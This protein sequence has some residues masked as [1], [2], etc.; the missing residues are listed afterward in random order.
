MKSTRI[1]FGIAVLAFAGSALA[2]TDGNSQTIEV[3]S[4]PRVELMTIIFRL[5]GNPEFNQSIT[6]PY[7]RDVD[8][9]FAPF[10]DHEA[11]R[12]ARRLRN[13]SSVSYD[14]VISMAMHVDN[15]FDLRERVPF[16]PQ[17]ERLD[18][19]W[20]ADEA[21]EF[22][23]LARQFVQDTGFKEF[24][25]KHEKI[26]E[27]TASRLKKQLH[28]RDYLD[29]LADFFGERPGAKFIAIPGMLTGGGCFASGIKL[30]NHEEEICMV[31]GVWSTD[32]RGRPRFGD[33]IIP[34][35]VHE[36][37]HSYTNPI[38]NRHADDLAAVGQK[39]FSAVAEKMRRQAYG[40][41]LTMMYESSVRA[42]TV[43]YMLKTEGEAAAKSEI[44]RHHQRGF[45][46]TGEL[47]A[48][49]GEYESDRA[50]YP[51]FDAFF[52]RVVE[53]FSE[54]AD[55]HSDSL[56]VSGL[57]P[58][59]SIL[60]DYV[61]SDG[62][63]MVMPDGIRNKNT[64]KRMK[65]YVNGIHKRFF[66]SKGVRLVK[67]SE[68]TEAD[69]KSKSFVLY[70]S[71]SSNA[72][73]NRMAQACGFAIAKDSIKIGA[74]EFDGR[75]LILISCFV[76]P[77]NDEQR[78]LFYASAAD[79]WV[80]NLNDFFHGPTDYLVGRWDKKGRPKILHQGDYTKTSDGKWITTD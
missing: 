73:L 51:N 25:N 11:V 64:A 46:W 4:D 12:T 1:A 41:W 7:V 58:I 36:Y 15:A 2:N 55:Q 24:V 17:P 62:M 14:A 48:L 66:A 27:Q 50:R 16:D 29:W 70:G 56:P 42:C 49:L 18:G 32:R 75:G 34:T 78:V 47:S 54:Y 26:Y 33:E 21:R 3:R 8:E 74:K 35:V 77:Y 76:N 9:Y 39:L 22:L 65:A 10:K 59:N 37:C 80:I 44:A 19:R 63:L 30:P 13:R 53:F 6:Y 60:M 45:S 61:S 31:L 67:A 57:G 72:V 28:Q 69:L 43:R 40:N 71:P 5:A 38:V 79:K 20:H 23:K 52:P 68:V